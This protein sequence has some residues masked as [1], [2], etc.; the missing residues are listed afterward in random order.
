MLGWL[1]KHRPKVAFSPSLCPQYVMAGRYRYYRSLDSSSLVSSGL[2]SSGL[3]SSGLDSSGL[4]DTSPCGDCCNNSLLSTSLPTDFCLI[5][6]Y[7]KRSSFLVLSSTNFFCHINRRRLL[8]SIFAAQAPSL[9]LLPRAPSVQA[10]LAGA[11]QV[12]LGPGMERGGQKHGRGRVRDVPG[13]GLTP[14]KARTDSG[15]S[16]QS[17]KRY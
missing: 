12:R 3:D 4:L 6:G 15:N 13:S 17:I 9:K 2:D 7:C 14:P 5:Y 11:P 16:G 10:P 8:P 1:S